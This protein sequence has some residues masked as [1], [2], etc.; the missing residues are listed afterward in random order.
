MTVKISGKYLGSK[1]HELT[2]QESGTVIV[3]DA[4]KDNNGLGSS[5]SPT[6][7]VAAA[8]GSC[9]TTTIAIYAERV[10]LDL[11]GMHFSVEKHMQ[12]TPRRIQALPLIVHLPQGIPEAERAK[13]ERV[14]LTCPVHASLAREV[15][16]MVKFVYD[17]VG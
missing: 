6:D 12:Q 10:G 17:V 5:F 7:L 1:R 2:H 3:T 9:V 16:A 11:S 14:G 15:Q 8:F 13:L 4:P